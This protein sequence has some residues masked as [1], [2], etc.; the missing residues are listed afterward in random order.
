MQVVVDNRVR[1]QTKKLPK[2]ALKKIKESFRYNNPEYFKRRNMGYYVGNIPRII[3]TFRLEDGGETITL[4]KGGLEKLTGILESFNLNFRIK[5][6]NRKAT[7][8]N[9]E[10]DPTFVL[11][12][13]QE[14]AVEKIL[15]TKTC[16]IEGAPAAG[17]TEIL[18]AAIAKA[19]VRTGVIVSD[20]NLFDQW[21]EA[22]QKR[23]LIPKK[24][25]GQVGKGKFKL[26]E[27]I[28]V[29]MQKTALNRLDKIKNYFDFIGA[30]EV[31][32]YA[33]RTFV[34][35]IDAFDAEYRVGVSAT[36][37]RKDLK[38]FLTHDLFGKI[39]FSISR[40]ELVEL[41]YTTDMQ[42]YIV[43]SEFKF[44]YDNEI[45]LRK[46]LESKF[47]D[48]DDLNV[49]EKRKVAEELNLPLNGYVQYLDASAQDKDRN[50][51]I[52]E[53]VRREYDRGS[54]CIIF[55][56][57]VE[58]CALWESSLKKVGLE[59]ATFRGMSGAK[60][61][62]KKKVKD[63]LKKLKEKKIR[64]AIGTVLDEGLN[65]PAVDAGFVVYRNATNPGNL[66]QQAGRLARLF[67]GKGIGR[68]YY[69]H[70]AEIP[71]FSD[72]LKKIAKRFKKVVTH[73]KTK[74]RKKIRQKR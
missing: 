26:G 71:R 48:Y 57:R 50:N 14:E 9:F 67:E 32:H 39:V 42:I 35:T 10:F 73:V 56:K 47:T 49:R 20:G 24:E 60:K 3:A 53:W 59:C 15:N 58:H 27:R 4:P 21:V 46:H 23:L 70:D 22:I 66:E 72:D 69:I 36:I 18:L 1:I 65:M 61:E 41:G 40:G 28:T 55:T 63:N 29:M 13:Y 25:I 16:L 19:G 6:K 38:H 5:S 8:V 31:H 64:I 62:E 74:K 30:D 37:K 12:P 52:Y 17:K 33:A 7:K 43:F 68:L 2:D 44:D 11:R 34:E 51:L 45:A 54:T